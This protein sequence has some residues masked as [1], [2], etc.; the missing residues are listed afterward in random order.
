MRCKERQER[1]S[2]DRHMYT[3]I[4]AFEICYRQTKSLSLGKERQRQSKMKRGILV[5]WRM[6][7]ARIAHRLY[8]V[9]RARGSRR[10]M[11]T[12]PFKTEFY[13][14]ASF[15]RCSHYSVQQHSYLFINWCFQELTSSSFETG[16]VLLL[17]SCVI[18]A[19]QS[20]NYIVEKN[21]TISNYRL[22]IIMVTT[23][24]LWTSVLQA[25]LL[26]LASPIYFLLFL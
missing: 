7:K 9:V 13:V 2:D 19:S 25:S 24:A 3:T 5:V 22:A 12:L 21:G 20:W 17:L 16:L 8:G 14:G 1:K 6:Q 18:S 10:L 26:F 15:D 4:V 11:S 23:Y